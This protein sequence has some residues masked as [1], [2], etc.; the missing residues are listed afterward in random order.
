MSNNEWH[1]FSVT[2]RDTGDFELR[3]PKRQ[4][5]IKGQ[6]TSEEEGNGIQ[7]LLVTSAINIDGTPIHIAPNE[8]IFF[9]PGRELASYDKET[10]KEAATN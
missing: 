1:L 2:T 8:S 9:H 7:R 5:K 6:V 4:L 3:S 10:L